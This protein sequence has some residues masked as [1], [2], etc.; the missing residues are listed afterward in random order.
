MNKK[1]RLLVILSVFVIVC[2]SIVALAG[3]KK[4]GG[5]SGGNSTSQNTDSLTL[6]KTAVQLVYGETS[7]IVAK[8]KDEGGVSLE[9]S[10]SDESVATVDGGVISSVGLG[11][12]T[13][14]AK[15]G[16]LQAECSVTVIF[17]DYQPVLIVERLGEELNLLKGDNYALSAFVSFNGKKYDCDLSAEI[18]DD[19]VAAYE[20]GSIKA[21]KKGQTQIT[22]KSVWNGFDT[23]LMQKSF[24][25]KVTEKDV[26]SYMLVE[27]DGEEKVADEITLF[28]TNSFEGEN[29]ANEAAV[30][31]VVKENGA[32]KSGTL[33]ITEGQNVI[34]LENGIVT[35]KGLGEAVI[36]AEYT[37]A[38]GESYT[39]TLK[40]ITE[41]P[42]VS[43]KGHVEWTDETIKDV[44]QHY[45][46]GNAVILSAKQGG[47]ELQHTKKS[48]VGV[49]FN[50]DETEPIE[51]KTSVGGYVFEDIYGCN[52]VLT[53]ENFASA[54]TLGTGVRNKYYAINGDIGSSDSPVDMGAQVNASDT[55]NFAGTFDGRGH[56]VYAATG[57]NGIFGGYGYDAVIKNAEFVITFKTANAVGITSDRG[58]WLKNPKM[59]ATIEN[60]HIVTTNF[61]ENNHVISNFKAELLKMKDVL[62]EVN[63]AENVADFDGRDN[64]GVL[65]ESDISYYDFMLA[66]AGLESYSNVR[67]VVNKLLPMAN[68]KVW[69]GS[70]FITFALNDESEFGTVKRV[71]E[72][73]D[74]AHYCVAES[75][76]KHSEWLKEVIYAVDKTQPDG[77]KRIK[78]VTFCYGLKNLE[79]GGI[80]RYNT[81]N[82]LKNA[83][84]NKV[85]DWI[86]G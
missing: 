7:V 52:A 38:S 80:Y 18:A 39:K 67:V 59:R 30:R 44:P 16:D 28:V 35:A 31:F 63:G 9:W 11:N 82:D 66:S 14:T 61:G 26:A 73:R 84:V 20:N 68:G 24:L 83:G 53:N 22:V 86:V 42:V 10:S 72:N 56:T 29:Y 6:T 70:K 77:Y 62:V 46:G 75:V 47:K 32:E 12:A 36:T 15:Y 43:Y 23:P 41:C 2:S 74:S 85:G 27:I 71:S 5:N 49:L 60:V 45:F 79:N 1:S 19:T 21:L 13:I 50:G 81:I 58:R 4:D 69:N 51:V 76:E 33:T 8:Y 57:E 64:V 55:S 34:N 54:L 37:G 40:V 17:G 65:F 78:C 3:C 25:V 48:L